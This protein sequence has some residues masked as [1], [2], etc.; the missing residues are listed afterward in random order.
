MQS[1]PIPNLRRS[2]RSSLLALVVL[3]AACTVQETPIPQLSGPSEL[4]LRVALQTVPDSIL[5]DGQSQSVVTIDAATPDGRPVRGLSLRIETWVDGVPQDFGTLSAKT[6]VTGD[7]GRARSTYTAPPRPAQ[8][9]EPHTVVTFYVIPIGTDYRG[10][11]P[12]TVDLRLVVPGVIQPPNPGAPQPRFTFTPTAPAILT[13]VTF[14]ASGTTD[15][16]A[17]CGAACTYT[18][19][20]GDGQKASGIFTT[21]QYTQVGTYQVRLTATDT[22]GAS[23]SAAQTVTVGGGTA[24][25]AAFT[26]SPTA[27]AISEQVFFTA[28]AS[29]AAPGRRIVAYNWNFGTGSSG[30]GITVL[31]SY[32]APGTYTVTLTVTDDAGLQGT[33]SQSVTV[34]GSGGLQAVLKVSPTTGGT[35]STTFQFDGAES[36]RGASPI[37]EYRFNFGDNTADQVG[38]SPVASHTFAAPGSYQVSLQVRDSAGRTSIA[39]VTVSVAAPTP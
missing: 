13:T 8:P 25:T 24:P 28:E 29:R 34:G 6:V 20:F 19:D 37:V 15:D 23:G 22:R 35:T 16:G 12:R 27:P 2:T 4:A 21:H 10:E 38:P 5:Q 31:R 1:Q 7:D 18:W 33:T 36:T 17:P 3:G 32:S 11:Q 30:T 26:F 9:V 39:R 14:D